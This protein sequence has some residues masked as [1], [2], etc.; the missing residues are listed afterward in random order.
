[1]AEERLHTVERCSGVEGQRRC[2]VAEDV[3][4]QVRQPCPLGQAID[5]G[6]IKPTQIDL[7]GDL[8]PGLAWI[9]GR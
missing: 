9:R 8:S 1:M 4:V 6:S 2:G 5:G 7:R 3:G